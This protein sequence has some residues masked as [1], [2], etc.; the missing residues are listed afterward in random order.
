MSELALG[1]NGQIKSA[2]EFHDLY[3]KNTTKHITFT[4]P[5]CKVRLFGKAIY[6]DGPQ[7]KSPHFSC[8]PQEPHV[9][10]CDGYPTIDGKSTIHLE[11]TCK[12]VIGKETFSLPEKLVVKAA[13]NN[14]KHTIQTTNGNE[15]EQ[16]KEKRAQAGRE[17]GTVKYTSSLIRSFVIA[18]NTLLKEI[19]NHAKSNKLSGAERNELIEKTLTKAPINL[20]GNSTN[21]NKAFQRTTYFS[22]QNKIWYGESVISKYDDFIY[23]LNKSTIKNG[24]DTL[25]FSIKIQIPRN[26]ILTSK[27]HQSIIHFLTKA[28]KDKSKLKWYCYGKASINPDGKTAELNIDNLDHVYFK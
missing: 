11:Q 27:R 1:D 8:Y 26:I 7:G 28:I 9:N 3:I 6:V 13:P 2:S 14:K 12:T 24:K 20:D 21:Y 19:Y 25:E 5:F 15:S 16:V 18:R 23:I 4:C 22:G 17:R 10:G